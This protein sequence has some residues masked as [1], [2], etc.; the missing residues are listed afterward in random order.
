MKENFWIPA[1]TKY[2]VPVSMSIFNIH[3][4]NYN[5]FISFP[6]NFCHM[7][8]FNDHSSNIFLLGDMLKSVFSDYSQVRFERVQKQVDSGTSL[9][10]ARKFI[11]SAAG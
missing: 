8:V 5:I 1:I 2:I 3:T 4:D 11:K 10:P 9:L 7:I 6:E